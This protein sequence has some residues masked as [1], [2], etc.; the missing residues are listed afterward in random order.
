M[1]VG[2]PLRLQPHLL[3]RARHDGAVGPGVADLQLAARPIALVALSVHLLLGALVQLGEL[4]AEDL[5]IQVQPC[6]VRRLKHHVSMEPLMIEVT[7]RAR[8]ALNKILEDKPG[9]ALRLYIEGYG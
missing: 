8:K 1:R 2:V 3:G 6:W 9:A 7:D 5:P 4:V